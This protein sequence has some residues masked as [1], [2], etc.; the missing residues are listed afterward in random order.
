MT[1]PTPIIFTPIWNVDREVTAYQITPRGKNSYIFSVQEIEANPSPLQ[2]TQL[3]KER[4][5]L[6][7]AFRATKKVRL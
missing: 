2:L 7:K 6:N 3:M 5:K 4:D 1:K